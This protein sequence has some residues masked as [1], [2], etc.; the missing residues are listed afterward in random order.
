ME[1]TAS[2]LTAGSISGLLDG[3]KAGD[4]D[5]FVHLVEA[6]DH[7]LVRLAFVVSG[8]VEVA[9]DAAQITW[10]RLWQNPPA[11]RAPDRLKSWLLTVAAN[12][13]R[14]MARRRR[15]GTVLELRETVPGSADPADQFHLVDLRRALGNLSAQERELV[16]LRFVLEM[17]SPEMGEHLGL[18]PEAVRTRLHRL[19]G[20]LR[21]DLTRE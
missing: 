15:R 9:K 5:A 21:E 6:L 1:A 7:D 4:Q 12:E 20:R 17:S 10:E 19:L 16:G 2:N 3:V 13:A 8:D 11:L 14:Q 18:S